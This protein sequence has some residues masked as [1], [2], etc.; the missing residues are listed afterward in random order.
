MTDTPTPA[1]NLAAFQQIVDAEDY[2][3]FFDIPYDQHFVN[4]NRLHILKQFSL[5][6]REID[7]VFPELSEEERLNKYGEALAEAYRVFLTASP[8]ETK[9]FKVFQDKPK[10]VVLIKDIGNLDGGAAE[11]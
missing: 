10:N 8:L 3:Q 11:A 6:V 4:V 7:R 5:L 1:K 9:L 2:F